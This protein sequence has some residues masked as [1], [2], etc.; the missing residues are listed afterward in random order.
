M[1]PPGRSNAPIL[2][3][4][5]DAAT[6]FAVRE[7]LAMLGQPVV[8]APS[9]RDALRE[10]LK[11]DF[12]LILL[13]VSMPEMDGYETA[14]MIRSRDRSR[15]IPIIFLS[16]VN[17]DPNHLF[18]GYSAGAVDY[19]FKPVAPEILRSK[20]SVFIE[21]HHKIEEV[22]RQAELEKS[23]LAENLEVRRQ[24][25]R[26]AEALHRSEQQQSLV[27]ESLP[28]ALYVS[29]SEDGFQSRSF[30][31]GKTKELCGLAAPEFSRKRKVW[32]SRIHD[33]DRPLVEEALQ[34]AAQTRT[35]YAEY[36][37]RCADGTFRWF[38]DRG[39]VTAAGEQTLE[40]FGLWLDISERRKLEQQLAHSQKIEA[41]GRMT[42]GIAHDFNNMLQVIV[43]NLQLLQTAPA[44]SPKRKRRIDVALQAAHSCSDMTRRL[45]GFARR[46]TLEPITLDM[47]QELARLRRLLAQTMAKGIVLEIDCPKGLW[48]VF[49]DR[50]QLESAIVNLAVNACDAMIRGGKLTISAANR[51]IRHNH[52]T[53][54]ELE[55]GRYVEIA[56]ADT[57]TGMPDH[58]IEQAFEPFFTT[59]GLQKGTGLGLSIIHGFAKQSGGG[60]RIASKV[61]QGT[62][63]R[64]FLPRSRAAVDT[65]A[66]PGEGAANARALAGMT[67]L[68]V[69][70][71]EDVREI[72]VSMLADM[73]CK[74]LEASNGAEAAAILEQS[75]AIS[76]LFS[77]CVMPG[78]PDGHQ[79]A[80]M[81]TR[82]PSGIPVL[83]TSA[84]NDTALGARFGFLPKP[85]SSAD[86]EAAIQRVIQ[87]Q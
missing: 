14:A 16:A 31:G 11:H 24:Q 29:S 87:N 19:V 23:L 44:D 27:I 34:R 45:L 69:D 58:V 17:T 36:R 76:L 3:V 9:G 50:S 15:G 42:G 82:R 33:D 49:A 22:R 40:L 86:L 20:V 68:V 35:Y 26:T 80:E 51:Q 30:V 1:G 56:V 75:D 13:D 66:V 52:A 25:S 38:S 8:C 71:E 72:A 61:G 4:D 18:R 32:L 5:D 83:L 70:D 39:T 62:V 7:T 77:D 48:P 46:Q 55:P 21:L 12:A 6:L 43:G 54:L 81:A 79:L 57:G 37:W 2:V 53:E 67:V 47:E 84:Y 63:V 59:K 41:I 28:L 78:E 64:L 73:G 85:Y 65:G 60:I 74:T 10:L